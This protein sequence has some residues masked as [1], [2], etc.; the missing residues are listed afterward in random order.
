MAAPSKRKVQEAQ[1]HLALCSELNSL[2]D[3]KNQLKEQVSNL[4]ELLEDISVESHNNK[5]RI[6]YLESCYV[7]ALVVVGAFYAGAHVAKHFGG[8]K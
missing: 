8:A 3:E 1:R 2:H 5:A 7:T 6:N 4:F